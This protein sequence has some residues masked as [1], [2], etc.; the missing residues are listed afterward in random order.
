M[1]QIRI[2]KIKITPSGPLCFVADIAA[3]HDGDLNRAFKL[4]E[5]AKASGAH[6]AKFQNFQA[7]KIV[8]KHGFES[9][10]RKIS[11]QASWKK[12]VY[13]T[14]KDAS[15][16]LDWTK[17]LK[18]KCDE[19][20]LEYFT[21]PYD[22][23]T[24]NMVDPFVSVYKIGSGDITWPAIIEHMTKKKKPIMIATGASSMEDV[25]RAVK[26]IKK[27]HDKIVLMQCNTNYTANSENFKYIN[28]N[29]LKT[30]RQ[31]YPDIIL[32]LSDH[33]HG[34]STVLGAI[35]MGAVVFEKHFTD[36][37]GRDGPDHKFAMNPKTWR[38][39]VDRANELYLALGN[40]VKI[41]EE[42]E[43]DSVVVQRR[44]IRAK[45]DLKANS[46]ITAGNL[47]FLRP[48]PENG[49][50]PYRVPELIGKKINKDIKRGELILLSD[51]R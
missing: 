18:N 2:G 6:A 37:N 16:P 33:T 1:R 22:F 48:I 13:E 4:I 50:P 36:D 30:F 12:S 3:N 44:A 11:H 40:G 19:V 24:V 10:S 9:L 26:T 41:V 49:L 21:S 8:S 34:H 35:A 14:Y 7:D 28:L 23:E 46:I 25:E 29:V 32:G 27:H 47:D 17:K 15:I 31:K 39:M 42:N 38:E 45:F 5:L 20:G 43:K 51:L